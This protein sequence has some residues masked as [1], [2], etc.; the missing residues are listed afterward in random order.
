MEK[1]SPNISLIFIFLLILNIVFGI[2]FS[3]I[4]VLFNGDGIK[5]AIKNVNIS[6]YLESN[7][8]INSIL[9]NKKIPMEIFNY[10]DKEEYER[11]VDLFFDNK[12]ITF[13]NIKSL[14]DNSVY[15]YDKVNML[16]VH[17]NIQEDIDEISRIIYSNINDK[18][19]INKINTYSLLGKSGI[20]FNIICII[21]T[22]LLIIKYKDLL[23]TGLIYTL[24]VIVIYLS[25]KNEI[26]F[27]TGDIFNKNV[28]TYLNNS[29]ANI[30]SIYFAVGIII[31]VIYLIVNVRKIYRKMKN[32]YIDYKWRYR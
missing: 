25:L 29:L 21:I 12:E 14:L 32:N 13:E 8:E 2:L 18:N 24:M 3:Y 4:N 1:K 30:C 28:I 23:Y 15:E 17:F 19:I 31:I 27:K 11:Q 26:V 7:K 5:Y 10:I 9:N 16:D 22:L 6:L 20:I